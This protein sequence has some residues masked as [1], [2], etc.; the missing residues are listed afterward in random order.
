MRC[1]TTKARD[2]LGYRVFTTG[3]DRVKLFSMKG[4]ILR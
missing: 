2:I 3:I 4:F 1:T